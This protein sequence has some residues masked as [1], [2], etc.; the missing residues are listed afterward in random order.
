MYFRLHFN[1]NDKTKFKFKHDA[2][3]LVTCPEATC[4]DNYIG[5]VKQ[6]ISEKVKDHN[7][8][9]VKLYH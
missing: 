5:E 1:I 9:D 8:G 7:D 3:Y 6:Q 2:I 4:N